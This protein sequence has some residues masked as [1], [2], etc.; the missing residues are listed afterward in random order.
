MIKRTI[1]TIVLWTIV[2]ALLFA[3]KAPAGAILIILLA[4]ATQ[5]ELY[6]LLEKCE[7]RPFRKLGVALGVLFLAAAYLLPQY[8]A[9]VFLYKKFDGLALVLVIIALTALVPKVPNRTATV[10]ATTFGFIYVPYLFHYFFRILDLDA[11]HDQTTGLFL[12][13]WVVVVVKFTDIGAYLIGTII[14][15]HKMAP[16]ISPGK[17]WEGTF[18]GLLVSALVSAGYVA[19]FAGQLPVTLNPFTAAFLALPIALVSVA[20]DLLESVIKRQAGVKDSGKTI[21]GIGGAFDLTDSLILSVPVA[22]G[23]LLFFV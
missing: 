16:K 4:A 22:Y 21:P 1:S 10:V 20:S 14:G 6:G 7:M 23:L 12:V 15:K 5:Y 8:S 17:T 9:T 19:L 13:F 18:G 11:I 3:F 2:I